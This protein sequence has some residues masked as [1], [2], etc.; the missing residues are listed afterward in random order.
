[1][2]SGKKNDYANEGVDEQGAVQAHQAMY[3]GGS[4][5]GRQH[6]SETMGA[7]AAMQ[8]RFPFQVQVAS[9]NTYRQISDT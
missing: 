4:G 5:E 7:G 8:V 1:M 3:G 6:S 2:L 9:P